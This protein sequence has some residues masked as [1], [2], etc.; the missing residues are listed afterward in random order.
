MK[1]KKNLNASL[2]A[3]VQGE[4][5]EYAWEVGAVEAEAAAAAAAERGRE[6]GTRDGGAEERKE[7]PDRAQQ[8]KLP[9]VKQVSFSALPPTLVVHLKRFEYDFDT[10]QQKK[11]RRTRALVRPPAPRHSHH[12]RAC[13]RRPSWMTPPSSRWCS[14]CSR[15]PPRACGRRGSS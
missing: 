6:E 4:T 7:A 9:T 12:P 14:T 2:E 3:F 1:G 5:V 11:V 8:V 13:P 10:M 15:T